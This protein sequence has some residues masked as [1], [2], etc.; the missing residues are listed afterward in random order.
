MDGQEQE[1]AGKRKTKNSTSLDKGEKDLVWAKKESENQAKK[2]ERLRRK[3]EEALQHVLR[4]SRYEA[5]EK[6][7]L[8]LFEQEEH[9]KEEAAH[10]LNVHTASSTEPSQLHLLGTVA[11]SSTCTSS[12]TSLV[13]RISQGKEECD[14]TDQV[15]DRD[16]F[17]PF[18]SFD[19]SDSNPESG[20]DQKRESSD[21]LSILPESDGLLLVAT[22]DEVTD[23]IQE[24]PVPQRISSEMSDEKRQRLLDEME[25]QYQFNKTM[26]RYANEPSPSKDNDNHFVLSE[27]KRDA[28]HKDG[29]ASVSSAGSH[30]SRVSR[31]FQSS[32]IDLNSQSSASRGSASE[33]GSISGQSS[34]SSGSNVIFTKEIYTQLMASSDKWSSEND[35]ILDMKNLS[36]S[37]AKVSIRS[38]VM[39]GIVFESR[40]VC[41]I[42]QLLKVQQKNFEKAHKELEADLAK[43]KREETRKIQQARRLLEKKMNECDDKNRELDSKI[44]ATSLF[45]VGRDSVS[46]LETAL[47]V[48]DQENRAL[49]DRVKVLEASVKEMLSSGVAHNPLKGK[50]IM[51]RIKSEPS[52]SPPNPARSSLSASGYSSA[53]SATSLPS[54]NNSSSCVEDSTFVGHD[55]HRIKR[56]LSPASKLRDEDLAFKKPKKQGTIWTRWNSAGIDDAELFIQTFGKKFLQTRSVDEL[57]YFRSRLFEAQEDF[58]NLFP[59]DLPM[60]QGILQRDSEQHLNYSNLQIDLEIPRSHARRYSL[61][62]YYG[63]LLG[64]INNILRKRASFRKHPQDQ[65]RIAAFCAHLGNGDPL[66]VSFLGAERNLKRINERSPCVT[67]Q[68]DDLYKLACQRNAVQPHWLHRS[69]FRN[70]QDNLRDRVPMPLS[71]RDALY[72]D[73]FRQFNSFFYNLHLHEI[74][75]FY[76][77]ARAFALQRSGNRNGGAPQARN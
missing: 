69:T 51:L 56:E 3:E 24:E 47:E 11:S 76:E 19:L 2:E 66:V 22:S 44:K 55:L 41:E 20:E 5:K 74:M 7:A 23:M 42:S 77:R 50:G 59:K 15:L 57:N 64:A 12:S 25:V 29:N 30:R 46:A 75:S 21:S 37:E 33:Q 54:S 27:E 71:D 73:S 17:S 13:A 53:S 48:S 34:N 43:I 8:A 10:L 61:H 28:D 18:S 68:F 4:V 38:D 6:G 39:A 60:E 9:R 62:F 72:N 67:E 45:S 40:P 26:E 58:K 63:K 31:D 49:K 52:C 32:S 16:D 70:I 36:L 14:P 65:K 35:V 1:T